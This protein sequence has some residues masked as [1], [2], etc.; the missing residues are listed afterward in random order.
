MTHTFHYFS[1][2][3]WRVWRQVNVFH[4]NCSLLGTKAFKTSPLLGWN[5]T[6]YIEW[7]SV[8]DVCSVPAD[9]EAWWLCEP[10][11][12]GIVSFLAQMPSLE[13]THPHSRAC[14]TVR[15]QAQERHRESGKNFKI[16]DGIQTKC[17]TPKTLLVVFVAVWKDWTK[18][19]GRWRDSPAV[20]TQLCNL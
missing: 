10:L 20:F 11:T 7:A 2:R 12:A 17:A 15:G 1:V 19:C 8:R 4:A 9:D 14:R 16:K 13:L 6:A 18:L 5:I 3:S